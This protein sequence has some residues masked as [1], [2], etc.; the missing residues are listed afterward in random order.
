MAVTINRPDGNG[1]EGGLVAPAGK[2]KD[3]SVT[4][5]VVSL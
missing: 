3:F 5:T 4:V 2:T 1:A